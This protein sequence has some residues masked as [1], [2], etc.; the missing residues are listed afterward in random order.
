MLSPVIRS[1]CEVISKL[2][3]YR[4]L[5]VAQYLQ[6]IFTIIKNFKE[7]SPWNSATPLTFM[8]SQ[9]NQSHLVLFCIIDFHYELATYCSMQLKIIHDLELHEIPNL[10]ICLQLEQ[11][12]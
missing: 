1:Q 3:I 6:L 12:E 9:S 8:T 7:Y 2:T 5:H 4:A 11:L 10:K